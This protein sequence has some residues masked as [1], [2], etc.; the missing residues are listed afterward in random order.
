MTLVLAFG[1][2]ALALAALGVY[3]VTAFGVALRRREF[4]IR[5]AIGATS[6]SLTAMVLGQGAGLA[7][8]GVLV[9]VAAGL[10]A[11]RALRAS[12]DSALFRTSPFALVP[13]LSAAIILVGVAVAATWLPARRAAR[14]DPLL[15]LRAEE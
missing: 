10:A 11:T 7:A 4:G 14:T 3:G 1:V 6:R 2:A 9:G 8:I 15:V 5:L 12:I 13:T